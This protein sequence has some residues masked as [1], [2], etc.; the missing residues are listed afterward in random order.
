V[1]NRHVKRLTPHLRNNI[2]SPTVEN[3]ETTTFKGANE[4]KQHVTLV[5]AL[6]IG[7]GILKLFAAAFVFF[8]VIGGGLLSGDPQAM[9]IT[10]I[11]GPA[12]AF[13]LVLTA[14]PG[15]IGGI[16]LLKG[17]S[18]ARILVLILAIF[19]L[20]DFPVGTAISIYTFWVLLHNE[21]GPLFEA[22]SKTSTKLAYS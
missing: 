4:M 20:I 8:A 5:A 2:R 18:W 16:G 3:F 21:T 11:V 13:F 22:E 6:N 15:I 12:V 17:K 7:F 10:A 1:F 19:D 9:A 14:L